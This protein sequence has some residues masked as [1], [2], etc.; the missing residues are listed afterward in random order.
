MDRVSF[1]GVVMSV[2]Q[3]LSITATAGNG[4][5]GVSSFNVNS[6]LGFTTRDSSSYF[7]TASLAGVS[8]I[9]GVDIT[10]RTTTQFTV[11]L[12]APLT[13]NDTVQFHIYDQL[14][15]AHGTFLARQKFTA[16]T[17]TYTPTLGTRRVLLRMVG[18]GGGGGGASGGAAQFAFGGGGSSGVYLEK[19][20][21][22]ATP[23]TGGSVTIGA[24]GTAGPTTPGSGG[25][26]SDTSIFIQGSTLT[27]KGGLGGLGA[28]TGTAA[29]VTGGVAPPSTGSS[30]ADVTGG[31]AGLSGFRISGGAGNVGPGGGNPLG[32]GGYNVNGAGVG[33]GFGAGGG[34]GFAST[35]GG[36]GGVGTAGVVIIDEYA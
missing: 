26:G 16:G 12:S 20:I 7:V 32:G 13:L 30:P 14:E 29:Q 28:A 35:T 8:A 31:E 1:H 33:T 36:S 27:A 9:L 24:G 25:V 4:L 18:G 21:D 6:T 23:I 10:A 34:G 22:S 3:N 15:I 19:S 11:T 2:D 5:V 17:S